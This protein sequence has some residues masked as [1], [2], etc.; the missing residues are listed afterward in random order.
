MPEIPDFSATPLDALAAYIESDRLP[1]VERWHPAHCGTID[2][3]ID[4][5]GRWYHEGAPLT[6]PAMVRAFSRILRREA[7]G[8]HVLVTPAERVTITVEDAAL[9]VAEAR[10]EGAGADATILFRLN[11]D[12][13]LLCGAEHPL[14]L[15]EGPAGLLP[16]LR[17]SGSAERPVEARLSR[18][19]YYQLAEAADA[20]GAVWS[21]GQRFALGAV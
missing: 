19:V 1:P 8:S 16:Y 3:R 21:G 10:I 14:V 9:V 2:I 5:E 20:S 11:T 15:R 12:A 6:R 18:P 7:D 4:A 13:M 17:V